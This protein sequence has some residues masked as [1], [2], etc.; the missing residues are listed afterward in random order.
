MSWSWIFPLKYGE[1]LLALGLVLLCAN[2]AS[3]SCSCVTRPPEP[4][5]S[6]VNKLCDKPASPRHYSPVEC[7]KSFLLSAPYPHYHLGLLPDSD[8]TRYCMRFLASPP[9]A[10]AS[11]RLGGWNSPPLTC[12]FVLSTF[13]VERCSASM[14]RWE[15]LR[16][17]LLLFFLLLCSQ[18]T[19]RHDHVEL[20]VFNKEIITLCQHYFL[21]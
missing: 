20:H 3:F 13:L 12:F 21:H 7:D 6:T 8:M 11:T 18:S 9:V 17:W 15:K 5:Y 19:S 16:T 14:V 4:V 10:C 2:S 1:L